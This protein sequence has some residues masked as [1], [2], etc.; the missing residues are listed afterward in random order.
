MPQEHIWLDS[1]TA[2]SAP[3]A[4][5]HIPN[6]PGIGPAHASYAVKARG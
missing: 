6:L 2:R 4:G 1:D 5:L 3:I